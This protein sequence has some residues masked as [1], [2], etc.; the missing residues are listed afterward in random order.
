[1][2]TR[3]SIG[4]YDGIVA[5]FL[6]LFPHFFPL[7]FYSYA[8]ICVAVIV[9]YQR[10]K[11]QS[12]R[13]LG[14]LRAGIDTNVVFA[15]LISAVALTA[16]MQVVYIPVIFYFFDV[17]EYTEYNFIKNHPL[18]LAITI[19]AAWIV[20]GFYEELVFRGFIYNALRKYFADQEASFWV[21]GL[22]TSAL[23][24][25]YHWQ[26]GIFGIVSSVIGG[27]F[28]TY[29]FKRSKGNLWYPIVSHAIFD[30]IALTLIY[31]DLFGR[32]FR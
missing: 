1:M 31:F 32:I 15:G 25:L 20:G 4:I 21:A 3:V 5:L 8:V 9:L 16:F 29:L 11:K 13:D 19:V 2:T 17:P 14:L 10:W 24:G 23:F 6:L 7:P 26:Q 30:T 12:L 27:M 18:N 22:L 28:W